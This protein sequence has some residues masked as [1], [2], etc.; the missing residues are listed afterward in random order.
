MYDLLDGEKAYV[1]DVRSSLEA[2]VDVLNQ[3]NEGLM[4][5]NESLERD[6]F[7]HDRQLDVMRVEL[8]SLC[9]DRDW[10]LHVGVVR[11]MNELIKH[12]EFTCGVSQIRHAAFVANE[13]FRHANLKAEI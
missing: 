6:I 8:E 2:R 13:E 12:P 9:A 3:S 5:H 7:D 11:V 10:L 1:D 4:I